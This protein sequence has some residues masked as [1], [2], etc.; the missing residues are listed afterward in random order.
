MKSLES[1]IIGCFFMLF[2]IIIPTL[3]LF[4]IAAILIAII[5]FISGC[6]MVFFKKEKEEN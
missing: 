3:Y 5:F 6:S 1:T 4:N 2:G